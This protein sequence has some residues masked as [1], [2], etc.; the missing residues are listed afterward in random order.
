MGQPSPG[1][2]VSGPPSWLQGPIQ[3]YLSAAGRAASRPYQQYQGPRVAPFTPMQEQAFGGIGNTMYG[4]QGLDNAQ[5]YIANMLGQAPG[6]NPHLS[7]VLGAGQRSITDAYNRAVG[8]TTARYNEPGQ[9]GGSAHELET[10][11]NNDVLARSL[12]ELESNVRY[13]DF[14]NSMN[15]QMSAAPLALQLAQGQQGLFEGGLRAGNVQQGYGQSLFDSLYNDWNAANNW[16][17]SS[18]DWYG[19]ALGRTMGGAGQQTTQT[20][21][22]N[23]WS[24]ALGAGLLAYG[25]WPRG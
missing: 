9:W 21:P 24:N 3:E 6:S 1:Q 12:G 11:N 17:R 14:N 16:D 5:G 13:Q 10:R 25:M 7:G 15:R 8:A 20:Q 18:L 19:G 23:P 22:N 2:T 4:S